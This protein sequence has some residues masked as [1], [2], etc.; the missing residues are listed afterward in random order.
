MSTDVIDEM[1]ACVAGAQRIVVMTGAGISTASG[2]P[3]FRG[4]EGFWTRHQ[5]VYYQDFKR[6]EDKRAEYWRY[7]LEFWRAFGGA[8]PNAAHL[9]LV[10]LEQRGQ[11][12]A[13]ITQNIDGLHLAAGSS[14]ERVIEIHGTNAEAE[15][16]ACDVRVDP[17]PLFEAFEATGTVPRCACGAPMKLATISFGQSLDADRLRR[18]SRVA[19]EADLFLS[20]GSSLTVEPAASIA[21]IAQQR[22]TPYGVVSRGETGHDHV[23]TWRIDADLAEVLPRIV[24]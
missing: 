12:H 24:G 13:L 1:A 2:I 4:N 19:A 10:R 7:K 15:C 3:D 22:G 16:I 8:K 5:P 14:P 9:A 20:L 18:A 11:L 23:A 21:L 6:F 17:V